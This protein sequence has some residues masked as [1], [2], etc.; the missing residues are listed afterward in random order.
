MGHPQLADPSP[1]T[2]FMRGQTV[3]RQPVYRHPS[4]VRDK[5]T[6]FQSKSINHN[7]EHRGRDQHTWL[8]FVSSLQIRRS[9]ARLAVHPSTVLQWVAR[10]SL[11]PHGP[12]AARRSVTFNAFY[13]R[14]HRQ[15]SSVNHNLP[16]KIYQSQSKAPGSGPAHMAK[17]SFDCNRSTFRKLAWPSTVYR[18]PMGGSPIS[19]AA[20]AARSSTIR[21]LQ[22]STV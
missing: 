7:Q 18:P 16:I 10:R 1:S 6:I 8:S 12:P 2:L 11:P 14:T 20:R 9:Q 3:N 17:L 5:I 15:P 13:E 21:H 4:T 22:R 19:A